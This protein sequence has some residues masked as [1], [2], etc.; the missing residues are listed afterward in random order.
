V[1]GLALNGFAAEEKET[2]D[3]D[4]GKKSN[5]VHYQ[6]VN[7]ADELGDPNLQN[8]GA[9]VD[10]ANKNAS[11]HELCALALELFMAEKSGGKKAKSLTA[12]ALLQTAADLAEL[13][14]NKAALNTVAA[15]FEIIGNS[16]KSAN[17]KKVAMA[18]K[19]RATRYTFDLCVVNRDYDEYD[20]YV[21]GRYIGKVGHYSSRCGRNVGRVG[22]TRLKAVGYKYTVWRNFTAGSF[23]RYTWTINVD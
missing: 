15:A 19:E 20:I 6:Y 4:S 17:Y 2:V 12:D 14:Q 1:L 23:R 13:Q 11:V 9:R 10:A 7:F 18:I 3:L 8:F 5:T 16:A 22:P 21:D